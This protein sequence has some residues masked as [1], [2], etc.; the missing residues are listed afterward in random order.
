[1]FRICPIDGFH[2]Y[3]Y[4]EDPPLVSS[5]LLL[6]VPSESPLYFEYL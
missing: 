1:M 3:L 4:T 6:K 5:Q 2:V